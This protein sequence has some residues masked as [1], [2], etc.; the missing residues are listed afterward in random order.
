MHILPAFYTPCG[1]SKVPV[2][3]PPGWRWG[4]KGLHGTAATP[5][6]GIQGSFYC[7]DYH[8]KQRLLV[9]WGT[10]PLQNPTQ[11]NKN[12]RL[13][14]I[15][16]LLPSVPLEYEVTR[17]ANSHLRPQIIILYACYVVCLCMLWCI[18][19][20]TF[21]TNIYDQQLPASIVCFLH[22]NISSVLDAI[23]DREIATTLT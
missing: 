8:V 17:R 6:N 10:H 19:V 11:V 4:R 21:I 12:S 23:S 7:K 3:R 14:T 16:G 15:G 18:F 1:S 5:L 2:P 22:L 9:Y 20:R 13:G